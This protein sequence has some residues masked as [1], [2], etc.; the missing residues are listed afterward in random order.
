MKKAILY[1]G[2]GAQHAGMG[3]DLYE[4]Y[5]TFAKAFDCANDVLDFDLHKLCF[6]DPEKKH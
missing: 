3:K 6:E 5:T 1:A 4:K 2:Q